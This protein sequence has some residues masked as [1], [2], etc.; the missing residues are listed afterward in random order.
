MQ[1][2]KTQKAKAN[3][4]SRWVRVAQHFLAI[5]F[6]ATGS[7]ESKQMQTVNTMHYLSITPLLFM[8]FTLFSSLAIKS[9]VD[10]MKHSRKHWSSYILMRS[11]KNILMGKEWHLPIDFSIYWMPARLKNMISILMCKLITIVSYFLRSVLPTR[12]K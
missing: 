12:L 1:R 6:K 10:T 5:P 3:S 2:P 11:S 4:P 8:Y 9:E 7:P